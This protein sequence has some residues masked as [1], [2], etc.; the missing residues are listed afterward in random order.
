MSGSGMKRRNRD[1]ARKRPVSASAVVRLMIWLVVLCIL[2]ATFG[3]AMMFEWE[4][5]MFKMKLHDDFGYSIGNGAT[6]DVVTA[7][8]IEWVSGDVTVVA[9]EEDE[10]RLTEDYGGSKDDCRMRWR[11][12]DGELSVKFRR[13]STWGIDAKSKGL[14]VEI[15]QK[16]LEQL[17]DLEISTVSA[18]QNIGVSARDLEIHTVSGRLNL[19]GNYDS[20]SI[21]TVSG[22]L[23]FDGTFREGAIDGVS[24]DAELFLREQAD[25]L[26]VN[27][28]SAKLR[29]VL[30]EETTGFDV[31][32]ATVRGKADVRGF[33]LDHH[34][35]DEWGD[36]SMKIRMNGVS[37]KLTIEKEEK[38]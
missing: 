21:E 33:D 36:G 9:S 32:V 26:A 10:I 4:D 2:L 31:D 37:S 19:R 6:T 35:S 30:P 22:D 12:K 38:D 20:V 1:S 23:F 25:R 5:S 27:F 34:G 11:V 16:M 24:G 18:T 29:L 17:E 7:I 15:P 14:T 8:S 13:S 28:V 3:I